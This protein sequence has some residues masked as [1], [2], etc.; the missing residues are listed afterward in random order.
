[1]AIH[2]GDL[3]HWGGQ[4]FDRRADRFDG[5]VRTQKAQKGIFRE[6]EICLGFPPEKPENMTD[7]QTDRQQI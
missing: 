5:T 6:N 2:F 3:V 4:N 7:E 1:V